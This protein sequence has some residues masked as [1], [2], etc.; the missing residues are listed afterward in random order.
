MEPARWLD[1]IEEKVVEK[2]YGNFKLWN[3]FTS[4]F[5]VEPTIMVDNYAM[6]KLVFTKDNLPETFRRMFNFQR[7][8][9]DIEK[10]TVL[11]KLWECINRYTHD[12]EVDKIYAIQNKLRILLAKR[13]KEYTAKM[14]ISVLLKD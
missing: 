13:E 11:L 14:D 10:C 5:G 12:W 9:E 3:L 1:V 4:E 2:S 7:V 6:R 8:E